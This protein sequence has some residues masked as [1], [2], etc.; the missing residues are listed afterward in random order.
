MDFIDGGF[1]GSDRIS[2]SFDG[3]INSNLVTVFEAIGD[4]LRRAVDTHS[5]SLDFRFVNAFGKGAAREPYDSK[6]GRLNGWLA[7]FDVDGNPRFV[8]S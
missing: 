2:K 6:G 1:P 7:G 8:W 4:G 5:N 3:D